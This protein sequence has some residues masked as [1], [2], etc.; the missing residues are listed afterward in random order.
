MEEWRAESYHQDCFLEEQQK[1]LQVVNR[2]VLEV[3]FM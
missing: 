2:V 1:K 3:L